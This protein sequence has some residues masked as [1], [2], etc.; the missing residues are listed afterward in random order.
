MIF[1][2]KVRSEWDFENICKFDILQEELREFWIF[3]NIIRIKFE[4]K[5]KLLLKKGNYEH[6]SVSDNFLLMKWNS[7]TF[8]ETLI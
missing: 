1:F 7:C 4:E 3:C 2:F 5:V 8:F 6:A